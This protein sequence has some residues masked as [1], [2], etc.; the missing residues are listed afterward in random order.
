[1]KKLNKTGLAMGVAL[2]VASSSAFAG[3]FTATSAAVGVEAAT[4]GTLVVTTP[5][6]PVFNPGT[7]VSADNRVFVTLDNGATFAN[8]TYALFVSGSGGEDANEFVLITPTPSGASTLEFRAASAVGVG[9]VYQLSSDATNSDAGIKVNAPSLAAGS[10]VNIDA[11]ADDSFGTF[12]FYTAAEIFEYANQ[13]SAAVDAVATSIADAT[14]DVDANRLTF[15]LGATSDSIVLEF[16]DAGTANGVTLNSAGST[17]AVDIVLT[18]DMSTIQSIVLNDGANDQGTFTIDEDAGTAT[19]S[20]EASDVFLAASTTL[21]INVWGS[22]A[23]ATRSFTVQADLNFE[24]ETDKNLI[25]EN[26]AAGE[27]GINGLQ[28]KVS[29]LSLNATGFISWL[30]VVN[31]GTTAAEITAD[32]IWTLADG[33][34]GSTS[35]ASLGSVDAGGIATVSEAS[36]LAAMGDPTQLADVSMTVTVAGQTNL[37]HLVAEKK[38]SDGRLPVPVYYNPGAGRNWI[39]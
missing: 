26:T 10:S 12:D 29:H 3:T 23:L 13:F 4:T 17:D 38:A 15:T 7:G 34:E 11:N 19:F 2:A 20:A 6:S 5:T 8:T 27:W 35:G 1:M 36:I 22:G 21:N 25:A 39:Q 14:I 33:T 31:E 16:A 28:A 37:I 18:G 30:K 32:I 24:S 9:D